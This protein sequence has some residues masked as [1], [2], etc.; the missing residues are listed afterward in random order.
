[1]YSFQQTM[2]EIKLLK[3]NL[4]RTWNSGDFGKIAESTKLGAAEFVKRLNLKP[5]QR[6]LDVAC[7]T[8]N[9]SIPAAQTGARVTGIDIAP[10]LLA[11]ARAKAKAEGLQ[12]RFEEGDAERLPYANES[13]DVVISM[14]GAMFAPRPDRALSELFR[15]CR[16]GGMIAMA[17]WTPDGF[18]GQMF[19][20]I[21]AYVP[22]ASDSFSPF[23][24][25]EIAWVQRCFQG[26]VADIKFSRRLITL[27]FEFDVPETVEYFRKYYGPLGKAFK[28]LDS[29]GKSALRQ[30][31]ERLWTKYNLE[32]KDRTRV[33]AEYLD[34]KAVV[35]PARCKARERKNNLHCNQEF[36]STFCI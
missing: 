1:M 25:G 4:K 7:G 29:K 16:R 8:G 34:V 12:I 21:S 35:C 33:E 13:F 27:S 5:V 18:I 32:S 10:N 15:V 19:R 24:W 9:Q 20:V 17:N 2:P 26:A 22:P 6:V 30:D 28:L 23:Q 14:F 11:Q 3:A 31:L 36:V